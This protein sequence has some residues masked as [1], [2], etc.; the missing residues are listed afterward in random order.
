[1]K[2]IEKSAKSGTKK[3][4]FKFESVN[5]SMGHMVYLEPQMA[6]QFANKKH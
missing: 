1:M 4:L 3:D 5:T 6:Q 2:S